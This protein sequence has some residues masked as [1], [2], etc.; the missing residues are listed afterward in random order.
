MVGSML[1][2]GYWL[3]TW[4][5]NYTTAG[6]SAFITGLFVVFVPILEKVIFGTRVSPLIWLGSSLSVLGLCFMIFGGGA[7]LSVSTIGDLLTLLCALGFA[8]HILLVGKFSNQE[9]YL[10]LLFVQLLVVVFCSG[11]GMM[12]IGDLSFPQTLVGWRGV[13]ITGVLATAFAY[14][15][16]NK[17]QPLS[18]PTRTSIIF[19][20]EP[21]FASLFGFIV[22]G[23]VFRGW[24]WFGAVCMLSAIL[25][26][27]VYRGD[28]G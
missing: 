21:V 17:F 6:N 27:N 1:F 28:D 10:S 8:L 12:A 23:E 18:T 13:L 22:L 11:A 2:F 25:L 24:Q 14:W 20:G 26:A 3:Q 19:S 9:N 7:T 4:G 15:A 16:Q 5:L